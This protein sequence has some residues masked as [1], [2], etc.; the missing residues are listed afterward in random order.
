MLLPWSPDGGWAA[1][2]LVRIEA[3]CFWSWVRR[4]ALKR[5]N[6]ALSA[7]LGHKLQVLDYCCGVGLKSSRLSVQPTPIHHKYSAKVPLQ[8][9]FNCCVSF[10]LLL[11]ETLVGTYLVRY[12]N[13][14]S[15]FLSGDFLCSWT[16]FLV[17]CFPNVCSLVIINLVTTLSLVQSSVF[18]YTDLHLLHITLAVLGCFKI[19][20]KYRRLFAATLSLL[21]LTWIYSMC[22]YCMFFGWLRDCVWL[23][24][25]NEIRRAIFLPPVNIWQHPMLAQL[26]G[27]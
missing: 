11:W 14:S 2:G 18:F 3:C 25:K 19:S 17:P 26:M 10:F 16:N 27:I 12:I 9:E 5:L 7:S 8:F 24:G 23:R 20:F 1:A 6:S 21:S 13:P 15:F 4:Q 22:N